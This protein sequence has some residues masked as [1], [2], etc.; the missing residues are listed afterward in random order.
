MLLVTSFMFAPAPAL[1]V[2]GQT[3]RLAL[4]LLSQWQRQEPLRGSYEI[5]RQRPVYF[6]HVPF[7]DHQYLSISGDSSTS[8]RKTVMPAGGGLFAQ[9]DNHGVR[10]ISSQFSGEDQ[11]AQNLWYKKIDWTKPVY[12]IMEVTEDNSPCLCMFP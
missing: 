10:N 7:N 9:R 8:G 1:V 5:S 4:A 11:H 2:C 6:S 3:L 12:A